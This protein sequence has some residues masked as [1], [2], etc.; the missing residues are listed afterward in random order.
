M[1]AKEKIPEKIKKG[2]FESPKKTPEIFQEK[3]K[4][5]QPVQDKPKHF[6]NEDNIQ[7]F[8]LRPFL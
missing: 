8:L 2:H 5:G 4:K 3:T 6:D 1:Y 7:D